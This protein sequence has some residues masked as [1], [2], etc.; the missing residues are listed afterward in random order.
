[1][2]GGLEECQAQGPRRRARRASGADAS[3]QG[4]EVSSH[5]SFV[6]TSP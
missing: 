4:Q 6:E 3:V 2:R 5:M 1:M